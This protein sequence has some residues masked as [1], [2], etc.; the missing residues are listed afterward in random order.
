ML[1]K[2]VEFRENGT[3]NMKIYLHKYKVIHN[4]KIL[5]NYLGKF[6]KKNVQFQIDKLD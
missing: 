2:K 4:I 5:D 1:H 3:K 6:L